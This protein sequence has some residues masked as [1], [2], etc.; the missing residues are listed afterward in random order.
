MRT[1]PDTDD[2][3]KCSQCT[4]AGAVGPCNAAR[5]GAIT[6][7]RN[8]DPDRNLLRRCEGYRPNRSDP[9]QRSGLQRW[10]GLKFIIALEKKTK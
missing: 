8:Y 2:R 3:R 7:S 4:Q 9:D 6:A 1:V 5:T 10:P